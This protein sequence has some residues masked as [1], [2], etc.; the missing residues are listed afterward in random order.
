MNADAGSRLFAESLASVLAL[1]LLRNY[2]ALSHQI[3]T[4]RLSSQPRAVTQA[5]S[6]IHANY[7]RD[8]S[9]TDV[10]AAAHLSPYHLTRLFKKA[11][12]VSPHRYLVRVRVDSAR[13]L[14]SAGA[15]E[16]SLAEIAAAVGFAD[17]SHL[18]RHFKR[19][20]G[21]TPK[22]LRQ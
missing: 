10:A 13:A 20:L 17:Q 8:I 22:Q 1:H 15:G 21:V 3:E 16:R 6:F 2:T 11:T 14:L 9:L 4:E 5:L 12:G 19:M 7:G 18:T